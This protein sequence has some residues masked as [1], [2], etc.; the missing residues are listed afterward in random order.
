MPTVR[1][2]LGRK[3]AR[4]ALGANNDVIS[5]SPD[6]T[7]LAAAQLM[8]AR[9]IGGL[10]VKQGDELVGIFTERDILRR[11]VNEQRPPASTLVRDVMTAPVLTVRPETLVKDCRALFT[12][13]RIRHLPVVG[14]DGV[15]GVVT[16]GDVI[17]FEADEARTAVEHLE[18]Y[19]YH[20]R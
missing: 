9:G 7:V 3:R 8:T 14:P 11:V 19:V 17:A 12:E 2:L 4:G 20:S 10:I 5:A 1:D 13:R 18:S 6:D 15:C 16:S